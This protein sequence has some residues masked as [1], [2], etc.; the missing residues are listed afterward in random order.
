MSVVVR[1][2]GAG[3]VAGLVATVPMTAV[4]AGVRR[5]LPLSEQ[6]TL[7]P[8]QVTDRAVDMIG[9]SDDMSEGEKQ[10]A[11]TATHLGFGATAGAGYGL[12]APHLPL[13][14]VV[15]GVAYG[16]A[17]WAGSYLGWLP[18]LRLHKRPAAEPVRRHAT[19]ILSHVVWG[20]VLG[21]L[22]DRLTQDDHERD[23]RGSGGSTRAVEMVRGTS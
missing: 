20:T 2:L 9:L 17:V 4:M 13:P 11:T 16:L 3:A 12:L 18:A 10:L 14:P 5:L 22:T 7:P 19:M 1:N 8:R 15:G 21:L 6:Q 23:G